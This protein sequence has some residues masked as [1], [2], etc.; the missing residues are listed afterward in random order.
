VPRRFRRHYGE[1]VNRLG[2][3]QRRVLRLENPHLS[4][5]SRKALQRF[6]YPPEQQLTAPAKACPPQ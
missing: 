5:A 3:E 2:C 4:E 6:A 1:I